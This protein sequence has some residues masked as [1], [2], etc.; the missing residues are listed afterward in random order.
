MGKVQH[1][2]L[3]KNEWE[4]LQH[5]LLVSFQGMGIRHEFSAPLLALFTKSEIIMFARRLQIAREL[6]RGK[7][8]HTIARELHIGL[9]TVQFVHLWLE[10]HTPS[11][12][13]IFRKAEPKR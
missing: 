8:F 4:K 1:R 2:R 10:Q 11:Y 12:M 3:T 6:L 13:K 5:T 7:A 9:A